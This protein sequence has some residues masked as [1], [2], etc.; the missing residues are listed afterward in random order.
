MSML[1]AAWSN[2][3]LT[4]N[5]STLKIGFL[6][7][8]A[9]LMS[10]QWA[11][12]IAIRERLLRDLCFQLIAAIL[13]EVSLEV[14]HTQ[15]ELRILHNHSSI[16]NLK[17]R[18]HLPHHLHWKRQRGQLLL[19]QW[20]QRQLSRKSINGLTLN[21][22]SYIPISS[23]NLNIGTKVKTRLLEVEGVHTLRSLSMCLHLALH[24]S[25]HH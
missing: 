16:L 18:W 7:S 23:N 2:C 24:I 5:G 14:T 4:T 25:I 21:L 3:L 1:N 13:L 12:Q 6:E 10:C 15:E 9:Y 22:Q 20:P 11:I 8:R 17:I 19:L